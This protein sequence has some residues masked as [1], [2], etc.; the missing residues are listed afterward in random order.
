[1]FRHQN[2]KIWRY[3]VGHGKEKL[4]DNVKLALPAGA[5]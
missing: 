2:K 3:S 1:M 5:Q 4:F